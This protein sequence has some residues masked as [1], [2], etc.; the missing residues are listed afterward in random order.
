[1]ALLAP[2]PRC[3]NYATQLVMVDNGHAVSRKV[4]LMEGDKALENPILK[5]GDPL[6]NHLGLA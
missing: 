2:Q 4:A 3:G 5:P 6:R 1:M